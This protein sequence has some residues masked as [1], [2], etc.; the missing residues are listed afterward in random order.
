MF[1]V[2]SIVFQAA[3]IHVISFFRQHARHYASGAA[4]IA[5]E[6]DGA[7]LSTSLNN[8]VHGDHVGLVVDS[9][10]VLGIDDTDDALARIR[11]P[12]QERPLTNYGVGRQGLSGGTNFACVRQRVANCWIHFAVCG[13]CSAVETQRDCTDRRVI[14]PCYTLE[15]EGTARMCSASGRAR[16][17][18]ALF[19]AL[20]AIKSRCA[21]QP[22]RFVT[23]HNKIRERDQMRKNST[24]AHPVR[25]RS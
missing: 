19:G 7:H 5:D 4:G 23:R 18:C 12:L 25:P 1:F 9:R 10:T 6:S 15:L 22:V 16:V 2:D 13:I 14:A 8:L 24:L 20:L 21:A 3:M 11:G 17:G